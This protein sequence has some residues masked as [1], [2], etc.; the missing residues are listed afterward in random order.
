[1]KSGYYNLLTASV[2]RRL[3]ERIDT[4]KDGV[5]SKE[6]LTVW[7]RKTEEKAN[8]ED[9]QNA[10]IKEDLDKDGY[11]TFEEFLT[12]SGMTDGRF[13]LH[14]SAS[15]SIGPPNLNIYIVQR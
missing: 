13:I 15:S 12:N 14:C 6:E 10:F 9:L 4:D 5:L 3:V 7:L 11:V 8:Q 2:Y 1:M